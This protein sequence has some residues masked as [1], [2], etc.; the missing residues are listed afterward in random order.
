[1]QHLTSL[2]LLA[3]LFCATVGRSFP[4]IKDGVPACSIT[5]PDDASPATRHAAEDLAL[6]LAK[7][8]GGAAG[9]S[10]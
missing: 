2:Y 8:S 3:S 5:V 4:L 10:H 9:N 7:I 1:M 6:Y